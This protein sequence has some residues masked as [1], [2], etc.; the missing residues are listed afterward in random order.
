MAKDELVGNIPSEIA[1]PWLAKQENLHGVQNVNWSALTQQAV[2][3]YQ[4]SD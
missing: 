2:G 1:F 3:V 4:G